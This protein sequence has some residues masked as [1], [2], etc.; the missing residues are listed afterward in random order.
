MWGQ[1][2][3]LS[4][5][6]WLTPEEL[7]I[8]EKENYARIEIYG[9]KPSLQHTKTEPKKIPL[10]LRLLKTKEVSPEEFLKKAREMKDSREAQPFFVGDE[11]IGDFLIEEM[12][13]LYKRTDING[14]PVDVV[15]ELSL[16]EVGHGSVH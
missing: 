10:K 14:N 5:E 12:T 13:V 15:I 16:L 1:L 4:F 3:E 7:T 11:Y 8:T 9:Q 6:L 2:G